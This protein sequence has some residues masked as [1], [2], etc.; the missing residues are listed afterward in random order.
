MHAEMPSSYTLGRP[1]LLTE[2]PVHRR[3]RFT[4]FSHVHLGSGPGGSASVWRHRTSRRLVAAALRRV[5]RV[6]VLPRLLGLGGIP[7]EPLHLRPVSLAV[8]F[9]RDF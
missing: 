7:G 6:D 5:P 9:P 4:R 3:T 8:L 2:I 1:G